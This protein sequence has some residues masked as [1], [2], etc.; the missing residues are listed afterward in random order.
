MGVGMQVWDQNGNVVSDTTT[1]TL[2]LI[3]VTA[4]STGPFTVSNQY[5]TKG[6]AWYLYVPTGNY[7]LGSNPATPTVSFSGMTMTV[8]GTYNE[9]KFY[10]GYY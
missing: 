5:L 6:T 7:S 1:R 4:P 2:T 10:Y 3:G 9:G 8:T